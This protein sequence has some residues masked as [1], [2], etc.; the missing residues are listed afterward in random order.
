MATNAAEVV[1]GYAVQKAERRVY[2]LNS[3]KF[4]WKLR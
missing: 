3:F 1:T 2:R 4:K